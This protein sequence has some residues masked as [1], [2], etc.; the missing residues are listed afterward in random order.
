MEEETK[1]YKPI[2]IAFTG[3]SGAGKD[4]CARIMQDRFGMIEV[5]ILAIATPLKLACTSLFNFS[6][7]QLLDPDYKNALD[8]RW[9]ASPREILQ[10]L[11]TDVLRNKF[12]DDFLLNNLKQRIDEAIENK[13]RYIIITDCRFDNEAQFIRNLG[14]KIYKV[15]RNSLSDD[16]KDIQLDEKESQW[17][18]HASENGI[19]SKYIDDII[20]NYGDLLD[21]QNTLF[22][23]NLLNW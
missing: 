10:W 5:S 15:E 9:G 17:K 7:R 22:K 23:Q 21:L 3:K 1:Q 13:A 14:G 20:P 2:I 18:K 4:S 8:V 16:I 19:D 6:S 12:G 11:G